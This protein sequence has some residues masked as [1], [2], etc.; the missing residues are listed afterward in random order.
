MDIESR[1][2]ALWETH[3]STY[4]IATNSTENLVWESMA[5]CWR[6]PFLQLAKEQLVA[7]QWQEWWVF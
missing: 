3:I 5:D 4:G 1:A 6:Y 7:E 2:K